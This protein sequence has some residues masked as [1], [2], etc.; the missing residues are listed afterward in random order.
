MALPEIE[1]KICDDFR[2]GKT[3]TELATE[4]GITY[5]GIHRILKKH[6]LSRANGGKS[7]VVAERRAKESAEATTSS[8]Q[9]RHG[10]TVEQWNMLRTMEDDY[11][12]TPLAAFNT[13]KNN[14]QSIND[15][16]FSMTLWEWWEMWEASGRW[17]QRIRNPDGMWVMAQLDK[18]LPL[19]KDNARI[20]PFGQLLKETRKYKKSANADI[21]KDVA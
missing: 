14:F 1:T 12:K 13:F 9:E 11:K 20:I 19:T 2:N 5:Q 15:V 18:T 8:I 3:T 4:H 10:C 16:A 6:G 17:T 7:K 21:A